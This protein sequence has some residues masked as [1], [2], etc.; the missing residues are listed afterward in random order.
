MIQNDLPIVEL[1]DS[2]PSKAIE[3]SELKGL[4]V[5]DALTKIA[6]TLVDF[7]FKLLIAIFIFYLGRFIIRKIYKTTLRVMTSRNMDPSLTTFVLSLVKMVLYFILIVTIIGILGIETSSFLALFASAGVAI[8]MALSGTLQNFA[9]G[10]LILL[11]KPYKVG[12]YIEA[13]GYAGTVKSIQLFHTVINTVDNK[14]III[15]NGG[16]STSS[17]N[18][19]SLENYRRVDWS[20]G[21]SYDTDFSAAKKTILEMLDSDDRVVKEFIEDDMLHREELAIAKEKREKEERISEGNFD[22]PSKKLKWYQHLI[23]G[24]KKRRSNLKAKLTDNIEMNAYIPQRVERKPFVGLMEMADSSIN[25][26][27]RVW[28]HSSNYWPLYFEMNERFFKELPEKGFSFPFPQLDVH[29]D[30]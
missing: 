25:L 14:A 2:I 9:G 13:Q 12:D 7:S 6:N 24:F 16:L 20:I 30:K 27:V 17:I 5:D 10:V 29:F 11:L 19:F 3:W 4:S 22:L 15:P 26:T 1:P 28:T 23:P 8:G 18:N 21:L